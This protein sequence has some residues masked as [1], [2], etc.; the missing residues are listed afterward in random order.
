MLSK[1]FNSFLLHL[2][3]KCM[4]CSHC[5]NT[6]DPFLDLSLEIVKADSLHKALKNFTAAE[7]L[8]GGERQYQCQ[9]CKQ[10]VKAIK[11][12]TV[13]NAPHVLAIHL[14]RFRAYDFGQKID[15]KVEFGPTLDMKPF[16]S[17][18]NVSKLLLH[19]VT[20]LK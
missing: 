9:R 5:S 6:F 10:K 1:L 2:Q 18:S 15:R 16:V 4:Q 7:L 3:V 8:D 12:L 11:Q 20:F 19:A 14:K 13:Y 17:G